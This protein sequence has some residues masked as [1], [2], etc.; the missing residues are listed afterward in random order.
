MKPR[1]VFRSVTAQ[2]FDAVAALYSAEK[3][4]IQHARSPVE[5]VAGV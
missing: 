4:V 1:E 2:G 5:M 3:K